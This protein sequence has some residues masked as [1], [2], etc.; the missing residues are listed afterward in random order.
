MAK[1]ARTT[2]LTKFNI[3]HFLNVSLSEDNILLPMAVLLHLSLIYT[4]LDYEIQ[5]SN[6]QHWNTTWGLF[7]NVLYSFLNSDWIGAADDNDDYYKDPCLIIGIVV[8]V[9][10]FIINRYADFSLRKLRTN[11]SEV[12]SIP[13]G[14]LFEVISYPNYF[15]VM[16][17]WF[18]WA[19][20]TWSLAGLF[21]FLFSSATFV[22]RARHNHQWYKNQFPDY[23]ADR[24]ALMP[25][26]Y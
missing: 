7:L 15:G 26:V 11:Y 2:N 3:L 16:L 19:L 23:P 22:P 12:Y 17:E 20:E 14:C 6:D 21:W 4:P 24:K 9:A 5:Q 18:G 8:F 13:H 1:I 10:R 25:F